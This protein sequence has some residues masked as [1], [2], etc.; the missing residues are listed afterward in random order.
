MYHDEL[1]QP[2]VEAVAQQDGAAGPGTAP[3]AADWLAGGGEMGRYIRSMDWSKTP[4]G[5]IES[6]P[7]SLRTTVSLCLAS[8]FPISLAWGPGH[9]QIY[10]DG[11]WP[12]CGGKHP[13][14]MGQDFSECWASAW[15]AIGEA[16]ESALTGATSFLEDQRMFLDRNGYLEETFFTFSFSPIRDE[17][18]GV[19]GLFHPVTETTGRMLSER[20]T[21][22][23]RDL[24][25]RT[26]KAQTCA[27]AFHTVAQALAAYDLD[28][29]F[30]LLYTVEPGAGQASLAASCGLPADSGA[31]AQLVD[32]EASTAWGLAR[33][34]ASG[35]PVQLEASELED[36][37]SG[38]GPYPEPPKSALCLPITPPGAERPAAVLVAGLSPRLPFNEV[39]RGFCEQVAAVLTAALANARAYEEERRRAEMLAELDQ[40]KTVFFSNVSHEFRTP[41]MLMLGPLEEAL[42]D[43]DLPPKQRERLDIAQ[44]N[45]LRLLKLVNI[46][47]DF[48]R[49]EAGRMQ[50]AFEPL[51]LAQLTADLAS[52]FRSAVEKAG[53]ELVVDC[54]QLPEPV[55]VD[56]DLW[57]KIV[58]NLV[59]NAF[60]FTEQGRISVR[61]GLAGGGVELAVQDTGCGIAADQIGNI[62]KRFHR[63]E[64]T[65]GRT[66]EGTGI[67]LALVHELVK[68][69]GGVVRVASQE[70]AGSSFTV[71]IPRGS[72]HLPAEQIQAQ[73]ALAASERRR[74]T[75]A[76]EALSW[77][78]DAAG[79]AGPADAGA[80]EAA[81]GVSDRPRVLLADD[82]ADMREYVC[83]ILAPH[84][85]VR[86]VA[87]GEAALRA[88]HE[89]APDLVLSDVMMPRL[90]GFGLL[91]ALRA[92]PDTRGLPVIFLSARA[93]DEARV[94]GLDAG[95]DDYLVKPF[96]G[97]ELLARVR[98]NLELTRTRAE[99]ARSKQEALGAVS[100]FEAIRDS[101]ERFRT[102]ANAIPQLCWMANADGWITWYNQRWYEFTGTTA[103]DMEGWGWQSVHDPDLLPSVRQ[104]WEASLASG[105]PFEMELQLRGADGVFCPFLTR[106]MPVKDQ[107][108]KVTRWF[109]TNTD[110]AERKLAEKMLEN[111][112]QE[113]E[114]RVAE[115]TAELREKDRILIQQNRQ[116]ALGEM[117]GNIAHQW[118]QPLNSL[119]LMVQ[120]M[121]LFY[122]LGLF[123]ATYLN[124]SV[125]K[126]MELIRYMSQTIDDFRHYFRP[127]REMADFKVS[128]TAG[129]TLEFVRDNF[130]S[131]GIGIEIVVK[132]D[133]VIRGYANELAQVL[134]NI[135]IN[136]KDALAERRTLEP[137]ITIAIDSTGDL[138][139]V[140]VADNAGGIPEEILDKIFDP[141]FTTKGPQQGTGLGLYMSKTILEKNMGGRLSAR[142][143]GGGAEFRIEIPRECPP[144]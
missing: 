133:P 70:G 35:L 8:N 84:Y 98:S 39:Y 2:V 32:L 83:R 40:A 96:S 136:A 28:L 105:E 126:C 81:S 22:A 65:R 132:E 52:V 27:E 77:L 129:K 102:L 44:R 73:A 86:A 66:F 21:R 64:G 55:F 7:Q 59:S 68:L 33:V 88:V 48:S 106:A 72:R 17:S 114:T 47:L 125:E 80:G 139:E 62:F 31:A 115:R 87:D 93:G 110:I 18:G 36:G 143:I 97:R 141:Y 16:F 6:W 42:G 91:G 4:L 118:R 78:P 54:P 50:A 116:A 43:P 74:E 45:S 13:H 38:C 56:R 138:V 79:A 122:E 26:G 137:R 71:T 103:A 1:F 92:D 49:I 112:N 24:S 85:Q 46:L 20:R 75:Y 119:G 123:N 90:D 29:P 140:V 41:L 120:Q 113:L 94:E 134:L 11:Y 53:L 63:I 101:E 30:V 23:L 124:Q 109:G 60:K 76:G 61:L 121:G 111:L 144:H 104:R 100:L 58:L 51:D 99:A 15:P 131:Q 89:Q 82:N 142:N 127:D 19:G 37:L 108:G 25:A 34:V 69:H 5:P 95:A 67:G 130:V 10:N 135:V 57:E 107:D 9:V 128:E 12:I 3:T 117:I 14:A